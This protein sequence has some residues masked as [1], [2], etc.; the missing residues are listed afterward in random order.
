MSVSVIVLN[1]LAWSNYC[2]KI[3]PSS[4]VPAITSSVQQYVAV[5]NVLCKSN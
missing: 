5:C 4:H 2:S 1:L 3:L